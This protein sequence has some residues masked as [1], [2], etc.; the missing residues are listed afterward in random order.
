MA[1]SAVTLLAPAAAWRFRS[2][3]YTDTPIPPDEPRAQNPPDGAM[4]DYYLGRTATEAKLEIADS[5]GR[6]I[7]TYTSRDTAMAP[8][9]IGNVPWYWIRP[10]QVLSAAQGFHRFVWDV[11]YD[12][13]ANAGAGNYPISAIPG[14]TAREPRGIFA[15]PGNYRVRL[16]VDGRTMTQPLLVRMDPRV[17]TPAAVIARTHALSVRLNDAIRRDSTIM[18]QIAVVRGQLRSARSAEA[19]AAAIDAFEA[20]LNALAGSGGAGG[21]RGGG[22]GAGGGRGGAAQPTF[23]AI[24][25]ELSTVLNVIQDADVPP[26]SQALTAAAKAERDFAT[27]TA[28]WNVLRTSDLKTLNDALTKANVQPISI[29]P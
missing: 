12:R 16:T 25:G 4:I 29:T 6:V 9:D 21:G 13:P 24:A 7:R 10:P 8:Q 3:G 26:T 18:A 11:R 22:R 14:N 19:A 17:K 2:Q 1:D 5:T 28:G 23:G 15:A 20:K 27:L